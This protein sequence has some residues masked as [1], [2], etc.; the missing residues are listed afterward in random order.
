[1]AL[2]LDASLNRQQLLEYLVDAGSYKK[3]LPLAKDAFYH[4]KEKLK[5]KELNDKSIDSINYGIVCGLAMIHS[6][7]GRKLNKKTDKFT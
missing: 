5:E 6:K 7:V 1:M 3:A 2:G 4:A